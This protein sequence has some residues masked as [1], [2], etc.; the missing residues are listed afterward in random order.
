MKLLILTEK[1]SQMNDFVTAL[2][3][4]SGNFQGKFDYV[5]THS[6]GHILQLK[7]PQEMVSEDKKTR[8]SS[9]R[10]L[11]YFPWDEND[12]SWA[13]RIAPGRSK[14]LKEIR[15]AAKDCDGIIIA[16][17]D[18]PSGEG[19]L[20]GWEI[21]NAIHWKKAVY[22]IRFED[23]APKSIIAAMKHMV[24]VTNQMEQG[25]YLEA[26]AR[27]RFDLLSMQL[28][29]I[30]MIYAKKAGYKPKTIRIGRLKSAIVGLIFDRNT[31]IE[32][33][34]KKPY[35][36]VK[37][38]DQNGNLFSRKF[39]PD[40]DQ[41]RYSV[42][43][44]AKTDLADYVASSIVIDEK[45]LK[46]QTPPPLVDLGQIGI[47][48]GAKGYKDKEIIKTYQDMYQAQ[49]VS[50]PRTEDTQVTLEQFNELLPLVDQIANVI[51][52]DSK[53]LTR[54]KPRAKFIT[55]QA[56]HGANRPGVKVP[57][58]LEQLEKRFGK[59]G[60]EIYQVVAKSYLAMLAEDYVYE[61][62]KAHLAKYPDFRASIQLP[63]AMNYKLIFDDRDLSEEDEA[64]AHEFKDMAQP[65]VY[66]GANPKPGKPTKKF[67]LNYLKKHNIGT[68]ATRLQT[69]AEISSGKG[70]LAALIRGGYVLNYEGQVQAIL[71]KGS[72]IASPKITKRLFD[73]MDRVKRKELD[74]QLI[75]QSMQTIVRHDMPIFENNATS[76][77]KNATLQKLASKHQTKTI[78]KKVVAGEK[79]TGD[80]NGEQI[81]FNQ[82]W[83][84]HKFTKK[85]I[86]DLLA[87]KKIR[88][89]YCSKKG[90]D[91]IVSGKLAKQTYKG[92][93]FYGFKPEF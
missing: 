59:I 22:R 53:L 49:I 56:A 2:G 63:K 17:D 45:K 88:I 87:G 13:K 65:F 92:R 16:T 3:G 26:L 27:Q 83:G 21:V 23:Q 5:L 77:D 9:W 20:L 79:V 33:Y 38:K 15:D 70:S 68:G 44:Q 47:L 37:F 34:V 12:F 50:Y 89:S 85:E 91:K 29:R 14:T 19:D 54:R 58:S 55:S 81:S 40:K 1:K 39:D 71:S 93:S 32:N 90:T 4:K 75:P 18:D 69:L 35:F 42:R 48:V 28:S 74:Y 84:G 82:T 11:K 78:N 62:Q 43:Q 57:K 76:L 67:I 86:A 51:G 30:A 61:A 6:Y 64:T 8:Y 7:E 73:G 60:V 41:F 36:E 25:E 52:V 24:N 46:Q 80:F 66:E 10:S 72:M 31:E